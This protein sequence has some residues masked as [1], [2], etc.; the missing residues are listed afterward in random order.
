MLTQE[1][2]ESLGLIND[3]EVDLVEF[4]IG[5]ERSPQRLSHATT[6]GASKLA[7]MVSIHLLSLICRRKARRS[8]E[9]YCATQGSFLCTIEHAKKPL[10][11]K[12][13]KGSPDAL[14]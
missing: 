10:T 5:P 6:L 12:F 8:G 2:G 9:E 1:K 11:Q 13:V 14:G 4:H 7:S 3:E